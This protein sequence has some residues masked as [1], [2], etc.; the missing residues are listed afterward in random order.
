[1]CET[2]RSH[3]HFQRHQSFV[4]QAVNRSLTAPSAVRTSPNQSNSEAEVKLTT[5]HTTP[6]ITFKLANWEVDGAGPK[7]VKLMAWIRRLSGVRGVDCKSANTGVASK[8]PTRFPPCY[9]HDLWPDDL[10]SSQ[11]LIKQALRMIQRMFSSQLQ[12]E[13]LLAGVIRLPRVETN[14]LCT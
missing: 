14:I 13:N 5:N 12:L 2:C 10:W 4:M 7:S 11:R 8:Q 6:M 1:M 3:F 9:R